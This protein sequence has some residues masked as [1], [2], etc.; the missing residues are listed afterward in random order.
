MCNQVCSFVEVYFRTFLLA[1]G[2][3]PLI[4]QRQSR[5]HLTHTFLSN[6]PWV[7]KVLA[8]C[9]SHKISPDKVFSCEFL[10]HNSQERHE[11]I[12][13]SRF[14]SQ[15]V[16]QVHVLRQHVSVQLE[17]VSKNVLDFASPGKPVRRRQLL[18]C[19]LSTI[20]LHVVTLSSFLP[21]RGATD[22]V[23][24]LTAYNIFALEF[25][26]LKHETLNNIVFAASME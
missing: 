11:V 9:S 22:F 4:L 24:L 5:P 16:L 1:K 2:P 26:C 6:Q 18:S 23:F 7:S 12:W 3:S 13:D 10:W 17:V 15:N 20:C 19:S 8:E 21:G 14:V 25:T